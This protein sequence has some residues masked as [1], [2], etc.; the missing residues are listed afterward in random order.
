MH[1]EE[2]QQPDPSSQSPK[3]KPVSVPT[4]ALSQKTQQ[5]L[6]EELNIPERE[7]DL[8]DSIEAEKRQV[9][10][11]TM[12]ASQ[13]STYQQ[14]LAR[15][16]ALDGL[17]D[18]REEIPPGQGFRVLTERWT[19]P[20]V[21][22]IVMLLHHG[23][24][25]ALRE[26]LYEHIPRQVHETDPA[27]RLDLKGF[28]FSR[29]GYRVDLGGVHFR[30]LNFWSCNFEDVNLKN[31]TFERCTLS[32][33]NF[34]DAYLRGC[35]FIDCDLTGVSFTR[36]NLV[37][38]TFLRTTMRFVSWEQ[39]KVDIRH[40][41]KKLEEERRKDWFAAAEIYKALRLNLHSVGDEQGASWAMY[42]QC[43]MNRKELFK[44]RL[45]KRWVI[46]WMLNLFWGYGEKPSRL[47][48][49]SMVMCICCACGYF[50]FGLSLEQDCGPG[51][52]SVEPFVYFVN[53]LYFSFVTFTTLGYGDIAPC[54]MPSRMLAT[55]EAFTGVFIMG[56]FVTANVRKLTGR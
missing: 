8:Q 28:H 30:D 44:K 19:A 48:W 47:F 56:L 49:F 37:R 53:C 10:R 7:D 14:R 45:Y 35:Q 21:E 40:F 51:W 42:R 4:R 46:S 3:T 5:R 23:N 29:L 6:R 20:R 11:E 15:V 25:L 18:V 27:D 26:Y 31:A 33:S 39:S 16:Q 13:T 38:A 9:K 12:R 34:V 50:A 24:Q 52:S 36:C 22:H 17:H 32:V 43:V 41:P 55:L 1:I 2:P 54:S